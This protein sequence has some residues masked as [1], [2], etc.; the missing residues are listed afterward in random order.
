MTSSLGD[1]LPENPREDVS[2]AY[3]LKIAT[4]DLNTKDFGLKS[5]LDSCLLLFSTYKASILHALTR[6]HPETVNFRMELSAFSDQLSA[7]SLLNVFC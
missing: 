7:K 2:L 1:G 4:D 5:T 3:S 6:V